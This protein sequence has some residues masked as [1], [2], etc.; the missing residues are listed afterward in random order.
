MTTDRV[1]VIDDPVSSLDS[2]ILFI[3]SSLIKQLF[4]EARSAVGTIKQVFVLTHN[5]YFHKEVSFKTNRRNG[6]RLNEETFWTV[7]K[8]AQHSQIQ[9]H[10]SNPIKT[11]YELLWLEVRDPDRS[12]LAIQNTLRRIIENYFK[13]LGGVDSDSIYEK[14][15]GKERLTCKSLFSWVNDGSHF[16]QDDLYVSIDEGAVDNY[17]AVFKEVFKKTGHISHYNMM[18]GIENAAAE[19]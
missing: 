14:F 5:V 8:P 17:L 15:E 4:E 16:A 6:G 19:G 9:G 10:E 12:N 11:S 7:R 13:I 2:D 1:I 18:M 3:V